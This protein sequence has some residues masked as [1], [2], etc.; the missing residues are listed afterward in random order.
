[1]ARK[2]ISIWSPFDWL[3]CFDIS[4]RNNIVCQC[5][6]EPI[7]YLYIVYYLFSDSSSV[8]VS[9]CALVSF[10]ALIKSS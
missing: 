7:K 4:T 2:K 1:M 3:C 6:F 8:D 10:D 5:F 9:C